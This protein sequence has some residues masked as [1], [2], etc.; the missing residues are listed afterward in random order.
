MPIDSLDKMFGTVAENDHKKWGVKA[1]AKKAAKKGV[2]KHHKV[3][4][5]H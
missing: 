3:H 4:G 5:K 1:R 2:H